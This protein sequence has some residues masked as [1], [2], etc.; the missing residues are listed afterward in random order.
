VQLQDA[1]GLVNLNV[2]SD[3]RL[4]RLLSIVDVP[5]DKRGMF[6]DTLRDYMDED[7]LTRINGAEEPEYRERGLPPPRNENLLTPYEARNIIGWRDMPQLW[8]NNRLPDLITVSTAVAVN[9]NTASKEVLATLP[10]VTSEI[11]DAII[12]RRQVAPIASP[13]I[14]AQLVGVA[15]GDYLLNIITLPADSVRVT[16]RSPDLPWAIQYNVSLSPNNDKAPWRIDYY[17]KIRQD[18]SLPPPAPAASPLTN[19]FANPTNLFVTPGLNAAK[20]NEIPELPPRNTIAV[21]AP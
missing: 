6:I 18:A 9:P 10:G 2:V 12:A 1:R 14:I 16:L 13:D 5:A 15:P 21:S 3:E 11:A 8:D 4:L 17:Y 19:P 7:S 20:A